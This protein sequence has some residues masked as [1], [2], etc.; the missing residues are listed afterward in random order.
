MGFKRLD[1]PKCLKVKSENSQ[2][3]LNLAKVR[4]DKETCIGCGVC[5][6]LCEEV[7]SLGDDGKAEIVEKYRGGDSSVGNAPDDVGCVDSA[8]ESCPVDAISKE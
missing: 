5:A 8:I 1:L 3:V 4:I 7:F 2:E 6:S